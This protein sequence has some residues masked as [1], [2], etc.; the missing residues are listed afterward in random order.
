M[1]QVLDAIDYRD[2]DWLPDAAVEVKDYL[3]RLLTEG[4][5]TAHAVQSRSKSIASFQEKCVRKGYEDPRRQVT[6]TVAVRLIMYSDIDKE[7]ACELVRERFAC[8]EDFNPG[9]HKQG[10]S[11]QGYDCAHL[12][13]TGE[14]HGQARGWLVAGGPLARYFDRFGGLEI[15]IRTVASHAWAEF[16]HSRRYKGAGYQAVSEEDR[17]TIDDL[18]REAAELRERLDAT[19]VAI[20][21]R[22]ANPTGPAG[23]TAAGPDEAVEE[24]EETEAAITD[25]ITP[26]SVAAYLAERF[27]DDAAGSEKGV[28]FACELLEACGIASI[29][30]LAQELSLI[31]AA[32]V[33]RLMETTTPVTRV[34][35][36]DDELLALYGEDYIARTAD[37]GTYGRRA[38]QLR[39]RY[40][41]LRNKVTVRP[42]PVTYQLIGRDCPEHLLHRQM[43]AARA[44]RE[45]ARILAEHRGVAAALRE[46]S[47]SRADDLDPGVR[48]RPVRLA[49]GSEL[50]IATALKRQDAQRLMDSL[51]T[52]S[53]LDLTVMR[54][55]ERI[56]R[57]G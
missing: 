15:Q 34:R 52:G 45:I 39:W 3:T 27:P 5:I 50:W 43:P 28:A 40:D 2:W 42:R 4:S 53:G 22:L 9:V 7:R 8:R 23:A 31:D 37:A 18:F 36:L 46:G 51:L 19:F 10:T 25:A 35:R 29:Q 54:D 24:T 17:R 13:V 55:G 41:R 33:R 47:I 57:G 6:D 1:A 32:E 20:E 26:A 38:D 12:V 49:D 44:V 14:A 11:R 56:L 21:E 16:E 30:Q 48:A